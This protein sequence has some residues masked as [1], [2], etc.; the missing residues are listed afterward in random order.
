MVQTE[1]QSGQNILST[2]A[3]SSEKQSFAQIQTVAPVFSWPY[4]LIANLVVAVDIQ[5]KSNDFID[6]MKSCEEYNLPDYLE[7][8]KLRLSRLVGHQDLF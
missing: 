7:P 3:N 1:T 5:K 4:I 8:S 6:Q 2:T